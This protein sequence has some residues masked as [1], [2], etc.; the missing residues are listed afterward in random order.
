MAEQDA[1][2][3][4]TRMGARGRSWWGPGDMYT[5]LV[6]GEESGGALFALDCLVGVGGGP[7]KHCHNAEDELFSITAGSITF[8]AGDVTL[9]VSAGDSVFVPRGTP[10]AY[11]NK[12]PEAARMIAVYTPAGM[13]GWFREVY[14]EVEDPTGPPPPVTEAMLSAMHEAG[15][16][17]NIEW[18]E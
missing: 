11:T 6:T 5:C 1:A 17:Y 15:P 14:A 7:P 4:H 18:L 12:G 10:H 16:R 13:E 8:T 3:V 2:V 9:E